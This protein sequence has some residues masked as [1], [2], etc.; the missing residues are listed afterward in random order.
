MRYKGEREARD[1]GGMSDRFGFHEDFGRAE[2]VTRASNRAT[3]LVFAAVFAIIALWPLWSSGAVRAWALIA[4]AA[5]TIV[6]IAI[7]RALGP[8]SRA[9]HGLGLIMHR[10]VSP[11]VM[12]LLFYLTVTPTGMLMRL[13]GKDP[14]RLRLDAE[15]KSYW[16][17][18]QPPGPAPETMRHQF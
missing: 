5:I 1:G 7:P 11:V 9:W 17:E 3:G 13:F 15:A 12:G 14:L 4:A 2:P 8:L 6:A 10:V 18:R 16:I